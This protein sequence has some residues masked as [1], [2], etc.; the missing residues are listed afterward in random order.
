MNERTHSIV[1]VMIVEDDRDTLEHFARV[2]SH[3]QGTAV[4]EKVGTGREAI[5]RMAAVRPDVLLVDLGL[6][7][8]HGT[9]VIRAAARAL[10]D[11]DIMVITTSGDERDVLASI[12][13]GATGYVLKDCS[14]HDLI[15]GIRELRSGG[16]PMSPGIARM[17]LNRMRASSRAS[18]RQE[19]RQMAAGEDSA[20][21]TARE[22]D[23]VRLLARG[24]TYS[25]TAARLGI[26]VHTVTSHIKNSYR[27]L[28]VHTA[29]AAVARAA[30]LHVLDGRADTHSGSCPNTRPGNS[31]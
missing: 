12:E 17:V 11:C 24:Y 27:K 21:L 13:S 25:E 14:D 30:E 10:R 19:S 8:V 1:R 3:G 2:V 6:P 5:A 23:V 29:A 20:Q 18:A 22:A 4:V 28:A 16:S 7:D 15:A 9:Q 26:S 31:S